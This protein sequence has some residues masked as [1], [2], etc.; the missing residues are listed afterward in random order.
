M[1]TT[2]RSVARAAW[3]AVA[4]AGLLATS[5]GAA[6]AAPAT[7]P[8]PATAPA[9]AAATCPYPY[10]CLFKD[11]VR[12]GQFQDVT[13]G[14][15]ALPSKPTGTSAS[16]IVVTNTRHD[17]VAYIRFANGTT[18]CLP[19]EYTTSFTGTLT[20]IRISSSATC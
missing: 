20:G 19:P 5:M 7:V 4:A 18:V 1:K 15:Q 16:P 12:I 2:R 3:S 6:T 9:E 11:G 14:F 8:A 17:D 10:V 13:S